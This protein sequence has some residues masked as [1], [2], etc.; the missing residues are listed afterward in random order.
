MVAD[1]LNEDYDKYSKNSFLDTKNE[2]TSWMTTYDR[3]VHEEKSTFYR[4]KHNN[5][6]D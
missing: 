3:F 1:Q 2:F 6:E 5:F 4:E